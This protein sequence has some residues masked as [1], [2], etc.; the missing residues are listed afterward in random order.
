MVLNK[1]LM[2]SRERLLSTI[3]HEEPDRVPIVPR[4]HSY[5][6]KRYGDHLVDNQVK[7]CRE[8]NWDLYIVVPSL[9]ESFWPNYAYD[10]R[11]EDY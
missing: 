1:D 8:F 6:M 3:R 4:Y 9:T 2:T 7:M 11:L 10:V 5:S